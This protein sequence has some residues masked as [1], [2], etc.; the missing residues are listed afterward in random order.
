MGYKSWNDSVSPSVITRHLCESWPTSCHY[1]NEF[2]QEK[3]EVSLT[4]LVQFY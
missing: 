3:K 1:F 2:Q 4:S